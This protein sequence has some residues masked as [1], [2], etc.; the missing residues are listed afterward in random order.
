[1]NGIQTLDA[2]S[3]RL[4]SLL[5]VKTQMRNVQHLLEDVATDFRLVKARMGGC[6]RHPAAR[7]GRS[8]HDMNAA[9]EGAMLPSFE[10][11]PSLS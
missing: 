2:P 9:P 8:A 6:S 10:M 4:N 7:I 11:G 1:M 3:L 5:P